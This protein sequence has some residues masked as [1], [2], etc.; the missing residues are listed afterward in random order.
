[1]TRT[2]KIIAALAVISLSAPAFARGGGHGGMSPGGMG[3]N[4][5]TSP[6]TYNIMQKTASQHHSTTWNKTT[7]TVMPNVGVGAGKIKPHLSGRH[8]QRLIRLQAELRRVF[9]AYQKEKLLNHT[10][11][12][13]HL[14][15]LVRRLRAE[16]IKA[17]GLA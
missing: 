3:S 2:L 9:L 4:H 12:A 13:N 15:M 14:G 7:N 1:M 17:G 10:A 5:A 11:A 8:L 16:V 6:V